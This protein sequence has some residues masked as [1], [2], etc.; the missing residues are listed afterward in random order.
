MTNYKLDNDIPIPETEDDLALEP[1]IEPE[2]TSRWTP[3]KPN[4]P[5]CHPLGSCRPNIG[6]CNACGDVFPC[7]SGNCGHLDCADP[8]AF[9]WA[10]DGNGTEI[11]DFI[12]VIEDESSNPFSRATSGEISLRTEDS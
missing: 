1:E 3:F 2:N 4:Q 9:G 10:C 8:R 6:R 7:P 12:Q 5:K 11:P